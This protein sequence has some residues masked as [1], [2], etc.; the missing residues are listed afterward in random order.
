[1]EYLSDG[2]LDL[3]GYR[4]ECLLYNRDLSY[5]QLIAPEYRQPVWDEWTRVIACSFPSGTNTRS[6]PP[7]GSAMGA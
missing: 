7:R 5:A 6:S 3:T 4:P 2:C 1:M